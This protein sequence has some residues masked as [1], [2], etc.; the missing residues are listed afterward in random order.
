MTCERYWQ[1]GV[2]LVEQGQ[3]DPHRDD[4]ADC[5]GAHAAREEMVREVHRMRERLAYVEGRQTTLPSNISTSAVD[6]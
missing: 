6:K 3:R 4:C 1:D 2:L 5:R